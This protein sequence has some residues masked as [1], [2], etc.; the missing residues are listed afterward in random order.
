ML[1]N[2]PSPRFW[3][4]V[5]LL[6]TLI[7]IGILLLPA[8]A[9]AQ[10]PAEDG[11]DDHPCPDP[12]PMIVNVNATSFNESQSIDL[13]KTTPSGGCSVRVMIRPAGGEGAT[14]LFGAE[15]SCLVTATPE[16]YRTGLSVEITKVGTC[17]NLEVGTRISVSGP[18]PSSSDGVSGASGSGRRLVLSKIIGGTLLAGR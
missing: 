4:G 12:Q 8:A 13:E 1:T 7:A 17:D 5:A 6:A 15:E 10:E 18:P 14:T 3:P 2:I 11:A 9:S 16:R